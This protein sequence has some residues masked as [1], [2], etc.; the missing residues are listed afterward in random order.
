MGGTT[1]AIPRF[2]TLSEFLE[3][4]EELATVAEL[5]A[6]GP[7]KT[8]QIRGW[9]YE[10]VHNRLEAALIRPTGGRVLFHSGRFKQWLEDRTNIVRQKRELV[11]RD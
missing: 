9:L 11:L 10:S 3:R 6:V 7:W 4:P 8:T 1:Q 2:S 5:S